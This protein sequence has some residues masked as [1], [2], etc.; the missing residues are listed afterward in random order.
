MNIKLFNNEV[1]KAI[2]ILHD[3]SY[4]QTCDKQDKDTFGILKLLKAREENI[5]FE[6]GL[7]ERIC[8]DNGNYPYR[9]SYFLTR[10]FVD[11]GFSY[12]HDG[13]TRRFWVREVLLQLNIEDIALVVK[14]GLFSRK[15]FK[16][17]N[18]RTESNKLAPDEEFLDMAVID[19]QD[20]IEESL[21][22]NETIDL[23]QLLK[24]N[25]N[26]ELIFDRK[27]STDD[28]DL[29]KLIEESKKRFLKQGDKHIALEKLW[30]AF[31]RIKTYYEEDKKKSVKK[32]I[33]VISVDLETDIFESEFNILTRIGNEYR[34]RHHETS[35]KAINSD[36]QINYLF[37]RMLSLID[38]CINKIEE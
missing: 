38:L 3:A 25:V 34:I 32:L 24:L 21:R 8:G 22:A 9:S 30:D 26:I 18:L 19:F 14:H 2:A 5:D 10:F 6:I 1:N 16:D 12:T 27:A 13:S 7:A 15:A 36:M 28:K 33:S 20:F 17:N 11:L 23:N 31:E 4:K 35:K 29:N 37:F